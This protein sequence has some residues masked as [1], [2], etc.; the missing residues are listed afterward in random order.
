MRNNQKED[1]WKDGKLTEI[2]QFNT[3]YNSF[4]CGNTT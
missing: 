4:V 1:G 2:V 3:Y